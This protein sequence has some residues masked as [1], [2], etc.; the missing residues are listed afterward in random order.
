MGLF[1]KTSHLSLSLSV[2]WDCCGEV[3]LKKLN[4]LHRKAGKLILPHPSLS[5]EQKMR[6]LGILNLLQQ[7]AYNKEIFMHKVL[8]NNS[9][10]YLHHSLLVTSPTI[11]TPG[12]T[13]TCQ[14][15][16]LTYLKLAYPS[17]ERPSGTPCLRI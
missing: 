1:N 15:Q 3:H 5:T 7:L 17:L 8:N 14:G 9:P 10:N 11:S 16:D 13:H 12:I 4:S 2:V 6:A